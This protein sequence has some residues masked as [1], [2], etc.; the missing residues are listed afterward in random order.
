MRRCAD[1]EPR[2]RRASYQQFTY[3]ELDDKPISEAARLARK[4]PQTRLLRRATR[5]GRGSATSDM[6]GMLESYA[7]QVSRHTEKDAAN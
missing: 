3:A 1:Y 4:D 5:Q 2:L 7:R 6:P